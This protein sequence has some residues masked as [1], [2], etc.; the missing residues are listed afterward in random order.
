[1]KKNDFIKTYELKYDTFSKSFIRNI[2]TQKENYTI[3]THYAL[4]KHEI[5]KNEWYFVKQ[6]FK[7]D[8]KGKPKIIYTKFVNGITA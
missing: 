5:N 7:D 4:L 3:I 6:A 2:Y 8:G 1:M